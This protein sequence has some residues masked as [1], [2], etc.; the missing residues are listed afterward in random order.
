VLGTRQIT[1]VYL[2][3]LA[4]SRNGRLVTFDRSISLQAVSGAT[5]KHLYV[6]GS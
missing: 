4:A 3:A 2:L 5:R 1:D 6:L